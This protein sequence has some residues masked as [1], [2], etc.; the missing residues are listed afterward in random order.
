MP[1]EKTAATKSINCL[2]CGAPITLRALGASVMVAC[3][4]CGTQIDVS[5]PEI[6]VIKKYNATAREFDLALGSRGVLRGKPFE[7]V[8][9]MV[10]SSEDGSWTEYLLFNPLIGFRWLVQD[11][12]HWSFAQTIKDISAIKPNYL[13]LHY[14][15]RDFRKYAVG[16]AVVESVIGEFYW[17]V[18]VGDKAETI[19][20]IAPPWLLSREK[21]GAELIWSLLVYLDP[22]EIQAA[23]KIQLQPRDDVAAHQPCAATETLSS[24]KRYIWAALGLA[25]LLQMATV[26]TA[27][28]QQIPIGTYT[29]SASHGQEAVFGPVHL[30]ATHS[31]N[32]LTAA[33]SL[34]NSWVD[35]DYA[36]VRKGTGESYEFS[37]SVE[38]YSGVDS[39]GAW[40]EGSNLGSS[41]VPAIPAG[42]Y[43][44]VVDSASGDAHGAPSQT[45][46][47]LSLTHNVA[48]WQNFWIACAVILIYPVFLIYRRFVFERE[49]W[50]D[51]AFN[52]YHTKKEE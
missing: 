16:N 22:A 21:T 31:L 11:R 14:D 33:T 35:L 9:A 12:S 5:K 15:N 41:L 3:P 43:D 44:V 45:P 48:P 37:N 17:R 8:G 6:Q 42:D 1:N 34:S 51:S 10:R 13:G 2:A 38:F 50:S 26:I 28:N 47:Q 7:I 29:P 18:K 46:I 27:R 20:Y 52:P 23:F 25:L 24:L 30:D 19:D 49:R 36:L 4:S 40:S 39:D 32:E